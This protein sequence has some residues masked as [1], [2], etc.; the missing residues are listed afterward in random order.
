MLAEY[1]EFIIRI[2]EKRIN[3]ISND[4]ISALWFELTFLAFLHIPFFVDFLSLF[5][6]TSQCFAIWVPSISFC[7]FLRFSLFWPKFLGH[8]CWLVKIYSRFSAII[9]SPPFW[10][11]FTGSQLV[12]TQRSSLKSSTK[13]SAGKWLYSNESHEMAEKKALLGWKKKISEALNILFTGTKF[14][15]ICRISIFFSLLS[16]AWFQLIFSR[17]TP[18]LIRRRNLRTHFP[19]SLYFI[20]ISTRF[21]KH[22]DFSLYLTNMDE[23]NF[24]PICGFLSAL[25]NWKCS[26][27]ISR[28]SAGTYSEKNDKT[29]KQTAA[30]R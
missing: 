15:R 1:M 28:T 4:V 10:P 7:N 2:D 17:F 25:Q 16:R 3:L 20:V 18:S 14:S 9:Y 27:I 13:I 8:R 21:S 29:L 12:N 26:K 19:S 24:V 11:K 5:F 30:K 23:Y 22:L 6:Q